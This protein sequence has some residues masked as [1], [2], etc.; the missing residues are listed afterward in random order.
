V[1]NILWIFYNI[2]SKEKEEVL[3]LIPLRKRIKE[4]FLLSKE[5][6]KFLMTTIISIIKNTFIKGCDN[7]VN[8]EFV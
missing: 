1:N 8:F 7:D 4:I 5:I 6:P 2:L 3:G